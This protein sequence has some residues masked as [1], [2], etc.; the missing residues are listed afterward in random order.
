MVPWM[1]D[2]GEQ[3]KELHRGCQK[4]LGP[5]GHIHI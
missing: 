5:D 3:E 2:Q 1:G 4:L